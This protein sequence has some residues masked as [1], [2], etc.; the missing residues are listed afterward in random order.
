M[1]LYAILCDPEH[2]QKWN[3]VHIDI[4]SPELM[5]YFTNINKG[6]RYYDMRN[7]PL[8]KFL[9]IMKTDCQFI[10]LFHQK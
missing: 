4:E 2:K 10:L 7:I 9:S 8:N 6:E 1:Q 5:T 3:Y